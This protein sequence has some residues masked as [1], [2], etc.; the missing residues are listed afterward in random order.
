MT[1]QW[2]D[3][4]ERSK[5]DGLFHFKVGRS[6]SCSV[7]RHGTE[8]F[9]VTIKYDS[10]NTIARDEYKLGR[11]DEANKMAKLKA[12]KFFDDTMSAIVKDMRGG[13]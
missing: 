1:Y 6:L 11:G 10:C 4:S 5:F 9:V 13:E 2:K 12:E 3:G 8:T 7:S